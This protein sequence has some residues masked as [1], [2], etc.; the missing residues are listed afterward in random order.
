[1]S[2]GSPKEVGFSPAA[3]GFT[4][5]FAASGSGAL[6]EGKSVACGSSLLGA[7]SIDSAGVPDSPAC[8]LGEGDLTSATSASGLGL[9]SS[10][11]AQMNPYLYDGRSLSFRPYILTLIFA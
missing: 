2:P 5:G 6:A 3:L 10:A 8:G 11:I 4:S 9:F 1:M 7:C